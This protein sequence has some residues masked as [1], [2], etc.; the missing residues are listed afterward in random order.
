V[1]V[2]DYYNNRIQK[3]DINGAFVTKIDTIDE[4]LEA[5]DIAVNSAGDVYVTTFGKSFADS[6]FVI[7]VF[8]PST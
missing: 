7:Q 8:S 4:K 3:F 5:K 6:L 2:P 1:Y